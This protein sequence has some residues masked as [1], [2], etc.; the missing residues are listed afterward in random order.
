MQEERHMPGFDL[1]LPPRAYS[2]WRPH[3]RTGNQ[4]I[5]PLAAALRR[6]A[7]WIERSR[8][9]KALATLDDQMLRDIGIT[10]VEAARESDKP[11]WR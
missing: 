1:P 6:I 10:R 2:R 4:P 5:P 3:P 7:A 9:R 11:F 8:Q